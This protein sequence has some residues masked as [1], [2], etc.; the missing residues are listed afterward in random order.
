MSYLACPVLPAHRYH[1][2]YMYSYTCSFCGFW[3]C[4]SYK[5]KT[6]TSIENIFPKFKRDVG[7]T[8]LK[9]QKLGV[10]ARHFMQ[11]LHKNITTSM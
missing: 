11:K 4:F 6:Q 10:E 3:H 8:V 5:T 7:M 1:Y 9:Q 2:I